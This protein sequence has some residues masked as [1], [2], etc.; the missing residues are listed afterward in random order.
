MLTTEQVNRLNRLDPPKTQESAT[1]K[2]ALLQAEAT[3][4]YAPL[5]T[6]QVQDAAMKVADQVAAARG[7][8]HE[9]TA[10]AEG[11]RQRL[12]P[13]AAHVEDL[14]RAAELSDEAGRV[15]ALPG[16]SFTKDRTWL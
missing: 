6:Q 3:N 12:E 9:D 8:H 14:V 5:W 16:R 4:S 7:P 13:D 2:A 11:I 1:I 15:S 10:R